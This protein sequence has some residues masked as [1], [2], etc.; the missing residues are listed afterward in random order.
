MLLGHRG[1]AQGSWNARLSL[2]GWLRVDLPEAG[3]PWQVWQCCS[4]LSRST[5]L[6]EPSQTRSV[7]PNLAPGLA[8]RR[9]N[10]SALQG[11]VFGASAVKQIPESSQGSSSSRK[12]YP[13]GFPLY[14]GLDL[15]PDLIFVSTCHF[16]LFTFYSPASFSSSL[17]SINLS[18]PTS[19]PC[20][21]HFN[22]KIF[23]ILLNLSPTKLTCEP[24]SLSS[25]PKCLGWFG[26]SYLTILFLLPIYGPFHC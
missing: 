7:S 1:R 17:S 26:L 9:K 14:S 13:D 12:C 11:S 8:G 3:K 19:L 21:L 24:L 2:P 4:C 25:S 6:A 23:Q 5:R 10:P 15:L 22:P 18:S 16:P 20:Q